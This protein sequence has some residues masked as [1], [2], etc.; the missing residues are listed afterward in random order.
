[1][2]DKMGVDGSGENALGK[3]WSPSELF[4]HTYDNAPEGVIR[5]L[6]QGDRFKAAESVVAELGRKEGFFRPD[7][8]EEL[9]AF[10]GWRKER[11][12]RFEGDPPPEE[13]TSSPVEEDSFAEMMRPTGFWETSKQIGIV[14]APRS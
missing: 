5:A 7:R 9:T 1:M 11:G 3:Q 12:I 2:S 6:G 8:D 10:D 14:P 4:R 13:E